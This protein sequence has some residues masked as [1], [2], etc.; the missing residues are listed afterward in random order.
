MFA[1]LRATG[2]PATGSSITARSTAD[3][4]ATA[5]C[6]SPWS[7]STARNWAALSPQEE[8]DRRERWL[9]AFQAGLDREYPGFSAAVT[10]RMFLN[11]RSMANFMNTPG[12]AI[13]GF[14]PLPFERRFWGASPLARRRRCRRSISPRPSPAASASAARCDRARRRANGDEGARGAESGANRRGCSVA[15][16]RPSARPFTIRRRRRARRQ[17]DEVG[18]A[19]RREAPMRP[20]RPSN[21]AGVE[22]AILSASA[23]G[24]PSVLDDVAYGVKQRDRAAG[25]RV[26]VVDQAR[27]FAPHAPPL[28]GRRPP[29][30][31]PPAAS[32]RRRARSRLRPW[33]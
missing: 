12:G 4:P 32:R 7:A 26:E 23:S 1:A 30:R 16:L 5:R 14:A 25:E 31:P 27:T 29:G 21:R 2:S 8:K 15:R 10:E 33:R 22:V 28:Q 9:D 6:S 24:R 19:A 13:Y 3:L 20:S 11:A 18:R 17:M